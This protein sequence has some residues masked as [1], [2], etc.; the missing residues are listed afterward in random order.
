MVKDASGEKRALLAEQAQ[1]FERLVE[2][3]E[4]DSNGPEQSKTSGRSN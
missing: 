1:M 4:R 2:A 3:A